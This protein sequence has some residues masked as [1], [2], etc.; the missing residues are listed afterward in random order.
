MFD[1]K[2]LTLNETDKYLNYCFT[3]TVM[4]KQLQCCPSGLNY[5]LAKRYGKIEKFAIDSM[6]YSYKNTPKYI[7]KNTPIPTISQEHFRTF[8]F[9]DDLLNYLVDDHFLIVNRIQYEKEGGWVGIT[10]FKPDSVA[11]YESCLNVINA[12]VQ[13]NLEE[14][15]Q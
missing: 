3:E 5:L 14:I 12:R 13:E 1:I 7:Y 9:I 15:L 10:A 2:G 8:T 4:I 11:F 6:F